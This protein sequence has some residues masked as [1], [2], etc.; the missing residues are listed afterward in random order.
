MRYHYAFTMPPTQFLGRCG[1]N[2][3]S[4][5][6]LGRLLGSHPL[7]LAGLAEK[8]AILEYMKRCK[9]CRLIKPTDQFYWAGNG[10]YQAHC[11]PC[12]NK[13]EYVRQK[14]KKALAKGELR[15]LSGVGLQRSTEA[16]EHH[17]K[18]FLVNEKPFREPLHITGCPT[19]FLIGLEF[20][21][22]HAGTKLLTTRTGKRKDLWDLALSRASEIATFLWENHCEVRYA[23]P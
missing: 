10:Y 22:T 5:Y 21:T 9:T 17:I 7:W 16:L 11:K 13:R 20:S 18:D 15:E 8:Y 19:P 1:E 2:W 4:M 23:F 14:R 6:A 3:C 12:S